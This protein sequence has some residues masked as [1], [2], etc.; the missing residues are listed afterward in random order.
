MSEAQALFDD[1]DDPAK[2]NGSHHDDVGKRGF[3]KSERCQSIGQ[4]TNQ[5][6]VCGKGV[7]YELTK[8]PR[9]TLGR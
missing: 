3:I 8:E 2:L 1:L 5:E 9:P 7:T 4:I 6:A